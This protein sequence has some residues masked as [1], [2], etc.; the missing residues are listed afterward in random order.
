MS[1]VGGWCALISLT[2]GPYSGDQTIQTMDILITS[3][4]AW[5]FFDEKLT[6]KKVFLIA[7]AVGA[8]ALVKIGAK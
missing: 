7:C 2:I 1:F 3:V 4:L 6:K 8:I 5:L